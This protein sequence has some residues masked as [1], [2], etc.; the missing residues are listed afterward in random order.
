MLVVD[1]ERRAQSHTAKNCKLR[2]Y[3]LRGYLLW[4]SPYPKRL[5]NRQDIGAGP[6]PDSLTKER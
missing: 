4:T 1:T 2:D 5:K 6:R 3:K